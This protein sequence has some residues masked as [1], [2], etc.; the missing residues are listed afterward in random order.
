MTESRPQPGAAGEPGG[1]A[2]ARGSVARTRAGRGAAEAANR[3]RN[4]LADPVTMLPLLLIAAFVARVVWLDLPHRSL[5]FDEAYYVNAARVLLG[6][7]VQPGRPLRRQPHRPRPQHGAPAARQAAHGRVDDRVRRQRVR[8]ALPS[9]IAGMVALVAVYGIGRSTGATARLS[10]LVVALLAF[11]NLTLVHGRI[12]TLD[13]LVLAPILV[14]SW[15]ALRKRWALAGLAMAIGVLIKLTAIYGVGAV[16]LLVLLQQGARLV[17]GAARA[18]GRPPRAGRVQRRVPRRRAGGA[19]GARLAVH[20]VRH[21]RRPPAPDGRVRREPRCARAQVGFCPGSDSRPWQWPFNEC[22]IQYLRVDVTVKAGDKAISATPRIDFRG[23]A[24]SAPHRHDRPGCAVHDL[25]RVAAAATASPCG[26]SRGGPPTICHTC[27]SACSQPHH[28]PLL[29]PARP[30]GHRRR[31]RRSCLRAA[32]CRGSSCGATSPPISPGSSRTSRS[33]RSP[34]VA[35]G[36][37]PETPMAREHAPSRARRGAAPVRHPRDRTHG[38]C[39]GVTDHS[40][41]GELLRPGAGRRGFCAGCR[42]HSPRA[43]IRCSPIA[44]TR[45]MA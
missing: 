45:P 29:L 10:L 6:W 44:S 41:A 9:V 24:Q 28:V 25:V 33:A 1:I 12:G 13:M 11:D 32:A 16:L 30:A 35:D 4:N 21:A 43:R 17:A 5:I 38:R 18:A 37:G 34:D 3:V 27:C 15:L 19:V 22:Q 20:D 40:L 39:L 23:R 2:G 8:L 31:D 36:P 7:T 14:G 26:P 42:P